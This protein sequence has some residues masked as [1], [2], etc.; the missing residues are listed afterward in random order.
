MLIYGSAAHALLLDTDP[1]NTAAVGGVYAAKLKG[2]VRDA[3]RK[4]SSRRTIARSASD[5]FQ[6][7]IVSR[8]PILRST[9][10][11]NLLI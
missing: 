8:I 1:N 7:N 6:P 11:E 3:H 9:Q 2:L 4:G 5:V 10:L